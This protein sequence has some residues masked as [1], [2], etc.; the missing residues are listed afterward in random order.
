M[1]VRSMELE[2]WKLEAW[3]TNGPMPE[4]MAKS[5][6]R[7]HVEEERYADKHGDLRCKYHSRLNGD[8]TD[9]L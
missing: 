5:S 3:Y 9:E 1:S 6:F 4:A 2:T 7:V 8:F